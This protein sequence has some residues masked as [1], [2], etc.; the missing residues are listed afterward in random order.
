MSNITVAIAEG[1]LGNTDWASIPAAKLGITVKY[2]PVE[3]VEDVIATS[4]GCDALMVS[5]HKMTA[6]KLAALPDSVKCLGRFGVG[7]D[8]IDLVAAKENKVPVIFQ[9]L[10]AFNEVANHAAAMLLALHRGVMQATLTTRDGQWLPAIQIAETASLQDSTLGVIG[11]GRIGRNFIQKMSPF[12]KNV[13]GYDPAITDEIPGV[14]MVK[15]LDE[16]LEQSK[17]ISMHAPYMPATHHIIGKRELAL[18]QK[19]SI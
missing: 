1:A 4:A 2:G 5:L 6:E 18:M 9:P 10:Y 14:T 19:G 7:L 17:F 15:N 16:L 12:F 13:L 3:T 8:S 11:C